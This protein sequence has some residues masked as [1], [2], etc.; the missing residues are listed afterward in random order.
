VVARA[1]VVWP[2]VNSRVNSRKLRRTGRDAGRVARPACLVCGAPIQAD[3]GLTASY[4]GRTLRFGCLTCRFRFEDEPDWHVDH[5]PGD[6]DCPDC[7][8]GARAA[9]PASEWACY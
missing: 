4:R 9:S 7:R 6:D 2:R 5:G 3:N 1:L 8:E